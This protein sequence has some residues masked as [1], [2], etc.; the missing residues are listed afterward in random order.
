MFVIRLLQ[1]NEKE[2][3]EKEGKGEDDERQFLEGSVNLYDA[4]PLITPYKEKESR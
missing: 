4:M 2:N 1:N 3:E